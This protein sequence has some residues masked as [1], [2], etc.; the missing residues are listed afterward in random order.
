[1]LGA[2]RGA[3]KRLFHRGGGETESDEELPAEYAHLPI[4]N[5]A[6]L[7][8]TAI[9]TGTGQEVAYHA[10][11]RRAVV[12]E[13]LPNPK[14]RR[15]DSPPLSNFF[16][17]QRKKRDQAHPSRSAVPFAPPLKRMR[18]SSASPSKAEERRRPAVLSLL[19][20]KITR[21]RTKVNTRD[22]VSCS[23]SDTPSDSSSFHEAHSER[24]VLDADEEWGDEDDAPS[25]RLS[26][27]D[28]W[29][30]WPDG[31]WETTHTRDY[32]EQ[33][34]S[35]FENVVNEHPRMGPAQLLAGRPALDGPGPSVADISSVLM[36]PHRIQY[37][38]RKIFNPENKVRD[39][40]FFP[41]L[42]RFK[43]KHPDWTVGV[44][45]MHRINVIVLQS[46]WQRRISLKDQIKSEAVNGV[47]SDA[48]HDYF[49]GQNQLLFLSSTFEPIYLKSWVPILM[50]YSNGATAVHYRIHF[51]YLFRGLAARCREIKRK[52]TDELF[53][54]VVDFS[55]AQRNGFIQAFVDFWLEFAPHGR[56]EHELNQAAAALLKGCRQHFDNQITRVARISRIVG[57]ERQSTFRKFA[58][59]LLGQKTM[60]GLRAC[61]AAL[62]R[63][64]PDAKPWVDWWMRPS[65]A[66]MLFLVASGMA[67]KL[68]ESLP[69]TTNA[70]A[71]EYILSIP[72]VLVLEVG[73][74]L[75]SSWK[76]PPNLLPLGQK[77][78]AKGVKY[79]LAA[80][81][82]TNY[83]AELGRSSHFIARYVTPDS[84]NI[85]DYDGMKH[86]GHAKHRRGA[87]ISGWL[88][89]SSNK[90]SSLPTGYRLAAVVYHLEGGENGQQLFRAERQKAAPWGLQLDA[91]PIS[92]QPF[93]RF[94]RLL[95][96]HLRQMTGDE[97]QDWASEVRQTQAVEYQ[98]GDSEPPEQSS[99]KDKVTETG[100]FRREFISLHDDDDQEMPNNSGVDQDSLDEVI[101]NTVDPIAPK[102]RRLSGA[103]FTSSDSSNSTT[104][105]PINCYGCG[106]ISDGDDDLEQVQ[107][108][109]CGFWSHFACQLED[110][111]VDWNDPE[112]YF[113]C[114]GC[115]P[116]PSVEL[117]S[118]REIVML[119]DP[120]AKDDWRGKD[121]LWFPARFFKH[122]PHAQNPKREFE[123]RFFESI[124][125]P[126][127]RDDLMRPLRTYTQDRVF[128][129]EILKA[130]PRLEQIGMIRRPAYFF[131]DPPK[132][133][134]LMK[135]FDAAV[136]PLAKLLKSFPDEH[137]VVSSYNLFFKD[138]PEDDRDNHV[139]A[140]IPTRL[141]DP[142]S[143]LTLLME[144]PLEQLQDFRVVSVA[145]PERRRR[146]TAVGRVML[147]LL[148]LQHELQEPLN[149]NGDTF[150][151]LMEGAIDPA[152][153]EWL[154][155]MRGIFC[156][157]NPKVLRHQKYW[158]MEKF[159]DSFRT[160][161]LTT[162]TIL[163][164][165]FRPATYIRIKPWEIRRPLLA[166]EV[167][168][169]AEEDNVEGNTRGKVRH[170]TD[171]N[172]ED[173]PA[174]KRQAMARRLRP[175]ERKAQGAKQVAAVPADKV[176]ASGKGWYII[177]D[178]S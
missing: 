26:G 54:N 110:D 103:T 119:P 116:R 114:Q 123:F 67:L 101:L 133:Y 94:A 152:N 25:A 87:K 128:C 162:H 82:Y 61:A 20:R 57:P 51:L 171:D 66:S 144:R 79:N 100:R 96:P 169:S 52:V 97:R 85:F 157:T 55:D 73:D 137:P 122:H 2:L 138:R 154:Q 21:Q 168:E 43:E 3:I 104:P 71:K 148:A 112:V 118:P 109:S 125:W 176:V 69:A 151:E 47:V 163:D 7:P 63:E 143:E 5:A 44:H 166:I 139:D 102:Q 172:D 117:F 35:Q 147:Q 64:F 126:K 135:I 30:P 173:A 153:K 178:D 124:K 127:T 72:V 158:D 4:Y 105:C 146:V 60:K 161:V 170:R 1:M 29:N 11:E 145:G 39:L 80:Q 37:E 34:Q 49:T 70:V 129:E 95:Q 10:T 115:R 22:S 120:R 160:D 177:E 32:F 36:N 27:P 33:S 111:E 58:K 90:L 59:A 75:G 136:A 84:A 81:I 19:T 45:W 167:T 106:E 6:E 48:C 8:K 121:V 92:N 16:T 107:C 68:W 155:A 13:S 12:T 159:R 150:E 156:A 18:R 86:D 62:I 23:G 131:P 142:V 14:R 174:V 77:F 74:S 24:E 38:R 165:T 89:G 9:R 130:V 98:M 113:T 56:K 134:A 175:R 76:V 28:R 17:R 46:P 164:S 65:H 93:A 88:S 91:N 99:R 15:A 53:A 141:R 140:W 108:T 83:T 40:R 42:E 50:T 132:N 41:K 31:K 149:L 78:A